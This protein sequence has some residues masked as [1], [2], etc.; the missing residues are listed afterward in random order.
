MRRPYGRNLLSIF[1]NHFNASD[2]VAILKLFFFIMQ[3][4]RNQNFITL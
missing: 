1:S 3:D 2:G 4:K